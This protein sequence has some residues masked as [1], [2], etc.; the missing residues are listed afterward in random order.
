MGWLAE[1]SLDVSCLGALCLG[2]GMQ[3]EREVPEVMVMGQERPSGY[4]KQGRMSTAGGKERAAVAAVDAGETA[5]C[6]G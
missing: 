6:Q 4:S 1:W 2:E 3:M 5:A